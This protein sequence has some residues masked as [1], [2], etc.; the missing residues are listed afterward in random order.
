MIDTRAVAQEVQ[1]QLTAALHKGHE[2]FRKGQEQIRKSRES[3]TVAVRTGSQIADAIKPS[4]PKLPSVQL[5]IPS[6][7]ELA[8]RDKLRENAHELRARQ[9]KLASHAQD[10]ASQAI[11]TQWKLSGKAIEA[12]SPFIADG[13]ARLTKAAETLL[14]GHRAEHTE[15]L[16]R[17]AD[18]DVRTAPAATAGDAPAATET[19]PAESAPAKPAPAKAARKSA[20]K[21]RTTS[22]ATGASKTA[23]GSTASKPRPTKK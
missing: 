1:D 4:L 2:Q 17:S 7:T 20:A 6:L 5:R 22:S 8:S 13:V 10:L 12:A 23:K 14:P 21:P 16:E 18:A 3:V 15:P 9:R 19:A 11:A